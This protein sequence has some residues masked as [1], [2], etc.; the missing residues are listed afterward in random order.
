MRIILVLIL[1]LSA[2]GKDFTVYPSNSSVLEYI[3]THYDAEARFLL[4]KKERQ[5]VEL[6]Y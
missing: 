6:D 3:Q 1:S 2:Y 4:T 5:M